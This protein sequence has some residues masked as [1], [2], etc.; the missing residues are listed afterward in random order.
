[1]T[2]ITLDESSA[3]YRAGLEALQEELD[4]VLGEGGLAVRVHRG[5]DGELAVRCD[6][7]TADITCCAKTQFFRLFT[8]LLDKLSSAPFEVREHACFDKCGAMFDCSR[9]AVLTVPAFCGLLRRMAMM[10]LNLGM[11]YTEDTYEI[12]GRPYFGYLRG[13]YTGAEL[14]ALD[15]YADRFGIEL[16]P[17]IQTLGHL[18]K[19]LRWQAASGLADTR[20][21]LLCGDE[22][23]LK[24][25]DESI[26]AA[27][28]PFRSK[29][30]HLGMDEAQGIGSG[31]Y[32]QKNGYRPAIEILRRHMNDVAQ[33]CRRRGLQPM[34]WSDMCLRPL[35]PRDEYYDFADDVRPVT[36]ELAASVPAD[37]SLVYWDYYHH[38]KQEYLTMIARHRQYGNPLLFA[39]GSWNWSGPIPDYGKTFDTTEKALAA[40]R[41]TGIREVFCTVWGDDGAESSLLNSL[42]GLQLYAEHTYLPESGE[43]PAQQRVFEAFR[44]CC[45]GDARDFW[46][47]RLFEELP[48]VPAGNPIVATPTKQILYQDVL[49]GLFDRHFAVQRAHYGSLRDWYLARRA[50]MAEAGRRSPAYKTLFA[51]YECLADVLADKAELGLAL[52][53]AYRAHDT[54]ALRACV[55]RLQGLAPKYDEL[56]L[57]WEAVWLSTNKPFGFDVLSTR[58]GGTR[59]RLT[60]AAHR[61]ESYLGGEVSSLP[62]LEQEL[63]FFD[64]RAEEL[65]DGTPLLCACGWKNIVTACPI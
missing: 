19:Y 17:C 7:A 32:L 13:R 55:G 38:T 60:Y 30:I 57:R 36:P 44:R 65:Q 47:L 16:V 20:D 6:G 35:S 62:E 40:C 59:G 1:M 26:A 58:L 21:V 63:L 45:G 27:S 4:F 64:G 43:A 14:K 54:A 42:L 10:G 48:G 61:V 15:D 22:G 34:I 29:R 25:L 52:R 51:L 41:E 49:M 56:T 8:L 12:P 53:A 39:G 23:V 37:I 5:A 9:N 28:A 31:R 11:L 33:L 18:E 24:F 3:G 46:A 2:T 50:D